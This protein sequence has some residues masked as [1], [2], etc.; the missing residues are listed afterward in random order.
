MAL[1][2]SKRYTLNEA[3]IQRWLAEG[4]GTGQGRSYLPWLTVRDLSSD[5]NSHRVLGRVSDRVHHLFSNIEYAHFLVFDFDKNTRDIREQ[6][7]L[8]RL[9]TLALAKRLGYKHP[10]QP[11]SDAWM[12]MTTDLVVTSEEN[13]VLSHKAYAIKEKKA[14]SNNR[15]QEKLAIERAYWQSQGIAFDVLDE[16]DAPRAYLRSLDWLSGAHDLTRL[17][18]PSPGFFLDT[19]RSLMA[20]IVEQSCSSLPLTHLCTNLDAKQNIPPGSHLLL[21]KHLI[22]TR[23]LTTDLG[24]PQVWKAPVSAFSVGNLLV[25]PTVS[26]SET[27]MC[28]VLPIHI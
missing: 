28:D 20:S 21:A 26:I 23:T 5:G 12:V 14:R 19:A 8:D 22:A 16:T 3:K 13:G 1:S 15:V 25:S 18:E 2:K 11:G 7:P 4:R 24:R 9:H 27:R 10:R 17:I 6:F